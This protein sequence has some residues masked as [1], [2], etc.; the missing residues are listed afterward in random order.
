[1][2][3]NAAADLIGR[4]LAA[5]RGG[6][7]AF[8]DDRGHYSYADLA[9]RVDRF[10]NAMRARGVHREQ[11]ILLCLHDG[12]D[13][14]VAFL[15]AIKA[16]I[17]PV[18]VNTA[19]SPGEFAFM[20]ADSRARAAIVSAP[21][22]PAIREAVALLSEPKPEIIVS[23]PA[24]GGEFAAMLAGAPTTTDAA[25]T[26]SDEPCFWLYSSGSTGRPKGTVHV[27]AS[28]IETAKR[29]A[30]PVLGIEETDIV[31]SA[32]KL[33]FAYG[34]G[35][36]LTFPMAVGATSVLTA[37]R[38]S[39]ALV[40]RMLREHRPTIFCGVPTLYNVMLAAADLPPP[41]ELALRRCVSAGEP[42]PADIG[43]RWAA[44][45]GV[46]ILDGIGSTEMLHI[47]LSNWP[48]DVRYGTTGRPV[49][50]YELKIVDEEGQP[51]RRGDIG[52]LLVSGPTAA[53]LYWNNRGRSRTTFLGPWTRTGD[54]YYEDGD[55]YYVYCGRSDDMMKV[56][57]M[58]VSPAEVESALIAHD[59]VLEAAVVGAADGDG[60]IKPKA[61]VVA[62]PG[63]P[64]A[65]ALAAALEQHTKGRLP[66]FKCPHWI[67][68]L[69]EL[70]KTATGKIQRF[71][72]RGEAA[73]GG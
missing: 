69:D 67:V 9:E 7:T 24:D 31:Y 12:I 71:K 41:Q 4:N 2:D 63:I 68:F 34:L 11:R 16:G 29:Y 19:L 55:G 32:A 8:I 52:D 35:N 72:L 36:A 49:P 47:F 64:A 3:Y 50:G 25:P 42:L 59:D 15:G 40:T 65:D 58:F 21:V 57:G 66:A 28:L 45:I 38:P 53:A 26:H 13:F 70:P 46:D 39:P 17:V 61:F 27:H 33:F 60:L 18:A 1:M 14:P 56:S 43:R 20:L 10:A 51:V 6:K 73:I 54:K 44:R 23:D 22:L 30:V 37:E 48:G 5:G 62:K